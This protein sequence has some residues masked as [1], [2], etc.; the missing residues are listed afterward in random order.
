VSVAK[1]CLKSIRTVNCK[2]KRKKGYIV[3]YPLNNN[4]KEFSIPLSKFSMKV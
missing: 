1:R 3:K 4:M 2:R